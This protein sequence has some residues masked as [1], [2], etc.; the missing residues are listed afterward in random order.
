MIKKRGD[1]F[2]M[3]V[4]TMLCSVSIVGRI[5]AESY[6]Y[7]KLN[8]LEKVSYDTGE[9]FIYKYDANGNITSITGPKQEGSGTDTNTPGDTGGSEN[10]NTNS[11]GNANQGQTGSG[12][13][14][15]S[16]NLGGTTS[17]STGTQQV[18]GKEESQKQETIKM[19]FVET[20]K[21]N[22]TV[23]LEGKK[24]SGVELT[25]FKDKKA[26]SFTVPN[27][28]KYKGKTYKVTSIGEKAFYKKTKLQKLTIGKYVKTIG[29]KAFYGDKKL[30]KITVK[31]T[32]LTKVGS[33]ALK[34]T[35]KKLNIKV[36]SKKL[37]K[38]KSLFK[39]KGNKKIKIS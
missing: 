34:G 17:G 3:V 35:N 6:E 23:F 19:Q 27:I 5:E 8:R 12:G 14:P 37:K 26:K 36:P 39:N 7:D 38:Y 24:V 2:K 4:L 1:L 16:T 10:G 28:I 21:A 30:V 13:N 32:S 20:K 22:Y 33:N 11:G 25:A 18:P 29:N 15:P 31:T 9:V